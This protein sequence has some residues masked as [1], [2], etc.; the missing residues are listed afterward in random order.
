MIGIVTVLYNSENVLEDFFKTLELQTIQDFILIGIDNNSRDNSIKKFKT[1]SSRVGFKT[2]IL[3]ENENWGI[4]KGNNIGI[5]HAINLGCDYVLLS[6]NDIILYP[7]TIANLLNA[8]SQPNISI[9]VP[10]ILYYNTNGH[11][12]F[13]GGHFSILSGPRH[14]FIRE[15][16]EGQ[17]NTEKL[18]D[19]SPTCFM[20]LKAAVFQQVGMMDETYFVYWDDTDF[21]WRACHGEK[22]FMKYV[23]DA[24]LEHRVGFS[25][26]GEES[27]FSIK[28]DNRNKVYFAYKNFSLIRRSIFFLYTFIRYLFKTRRELT[29]EKRSLV[30]NSWKDGF[31]LY[32]NTYY[33]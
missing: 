11:I 31:N 1:L 23:P 21:I 24:C 13:G 28:Y 30:I 12:W 33:K 26:G 4:A 20:L 27:D 10:K 3:E 25:S 16:D 7:N 29:P 22:L 32:K 2:V 17:A 6:N 9:T 5:I 14:D 19:Y 15:K 18:I 8:I